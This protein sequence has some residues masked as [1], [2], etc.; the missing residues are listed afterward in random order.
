MGALPPTSK[1]LR[2]L[3]APPDI[4]QQK[5][6]GPAASSWSK[7]FRRRLRSACQTGLLHQAGGFFFQQA[8]LARA[9]DRGAADLKE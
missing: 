1:I 6:N 9:L 5:K 8:V 7:Y 3:N 2:I 4:F